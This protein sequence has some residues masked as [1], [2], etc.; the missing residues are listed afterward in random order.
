MKI[1]HTP[2]CFLFLTDSNVN[3][4]SKALQERLFDVPAAES[5]RLVLECNDG[6]SVVVSR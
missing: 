2:A 3:E 5:D 1:Q 6:K 4:L